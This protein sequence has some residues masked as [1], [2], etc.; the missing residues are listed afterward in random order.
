MKDV[1]KSSSNNLIKYIKSLRIKKFRDKYG[2]FMI[3]GEKL[4]AEALNYKASVSMVLLSRNYWEKGRHET[5][6]GML[7]ESHIPLYYT[8]DNIFKEVCETDTPQGVLAVVRKLEFDLS[9]VMARD[10]L[11]VVLLHEARDPGNVGTIIRA[12]DACG[13]DAV[14]ISKD[15]VDLYNGKTIRAT[16]GS[17]FHIPVFQDMDTEETISMLRD[18]KVITVGSDPRSSIS[19]IELPHY[20][21]TAILVGNESQGLSGKI[22]AL[23]DVNVKIPMPGRAESLNAGMAA[24]ILMYEIS[25]RKEK[26]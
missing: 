6:S 24:A 25:V 17:L 10:E 4:L 12:A 3:E 7:S 19:C 20:K 11:C 16:M 13:L 26:Q 9:A 21:R 5:L 15:S 22:Q 2:E 14:L 8:E 23:L 18:G 1:I